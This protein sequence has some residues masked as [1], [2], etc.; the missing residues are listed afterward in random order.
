MDHRKRPIVHVP[1]QMPELRESPIKERIAESF[2]ED[3]EGRLTFEDFVDM[4]SELCELAPC[5][6]KANH[7]FKIY[8]FICEEALEMTLARLTKSEPEED[9]V[10]DKVIEEA[11]LDGDGKL[12]YSDFEDMIVAAFTKH[13][14]PPVSKLRSPKLGVYQCT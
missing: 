6:L 2:S 10:Y 9:E 11:D 12:G 7:A 3:G 1:I 4:L 13:R 5:D 14:T 8:D